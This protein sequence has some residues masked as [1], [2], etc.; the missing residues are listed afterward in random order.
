MLRCLSE[1]WS[2]SAVL[3]PELDERKPDQFG[4]HGF[5]NIA[6][7][8]HVQRPFPILCRPSRA[9]SCWVTSA[10]PGKVDTVEIDTELGPPPGTSSGVVSGTGSAGASTSGAS[11][12]VAPDS[13]ARI[14]GAPRK[15]GRCEGADEQGEELKATHSGAPGSRLRIW[16]R[17]KMPASSCKARTGTTQY[18]FRPD[19]RLC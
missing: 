19:H 11:T 16:L 14:L 6:E 7:P 4:E 3:G 10:I 15:H 13:G 18:C 2:W 9:S 17:T 12:M 1:G 5:I 8:F